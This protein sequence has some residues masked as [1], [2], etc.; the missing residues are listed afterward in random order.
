M[1]VQVIA[2]RAGADDADALAD[3]LARA[4]DDDPVSRWVFPDDARRLA[5]QRL[6]FRVVVD[7][8]LAGG[9]AWTTAGR[10]GVALWLPV[11][12]SEPDG[13][14]DAFRTDVR[15]ALGADAGRFLALEELMHAA[16]PTH[17]SHQYLPFI[18]VDPDRQGT[19]V[20]SALLRHRFARLDEMKAPAYLEAS[21]PRNRVLY[22][23]LGFHDLGPPIAP[24][25]GPSLWPMWRPA[26]T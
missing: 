2:R 13:D 10:A 14:R 8:A 9:E 16:H 15:D 26:S 22:A 20:G 12:V 19:G 4:F 17:E 18:A 23:R 3:L 5:A 25:G 21:S 11:D 1:A 24:P 7:G 6:L